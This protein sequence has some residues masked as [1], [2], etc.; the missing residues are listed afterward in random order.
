MVPRARGTGG[1]VGGGLCFPTPTSRTGSAG[2]HNRDGGSPGAEDAGSRKEC[3]RP[4][5]LALAQNP[6]PCRSACRG[7]G[8]SG[9]G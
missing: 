3:R 9:C 1:S 8:S 2:S 7:R 4:A 5:A 6:R